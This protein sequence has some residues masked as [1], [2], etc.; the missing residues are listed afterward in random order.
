MRKNSLLAFVLFIFTIITIS[1]IDIF[2]ANTTVSDFPDETITQVD[3]SDFEYIILARRGGGFS[4]SRGSSSRSSSWGGS[5][6]SSSSSK[7]STGS[8]WGEP[9]KSSTK[10]GYSSGGKSDK[11]PTSTTGNSNS[12]S[13]TRSPASKNTTPTQQKADSAAYKAA[14]QKGTAFK[15]KAEATSYFKKNADTKYPSKFEVKPTTR[16][17]YIPEKYMVNGK[18]VNVSW[19]PTHSS[20]GYVDP[21]SNAFVAYSVANMAS[22]KPICGPLCRGF[23]GRRRIS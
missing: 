13:G 14:Q 9:A 1:T 12:L 16:P 6:K 3:T 7:K 21:I 17:E 19:N 20:Y 8:G 15:T 2:A 22:Q 5:S 4:S 11:T 10:S 23:P 18:S